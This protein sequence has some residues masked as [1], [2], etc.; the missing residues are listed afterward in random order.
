MREGMIPLAAKLSRSV[1]PLGARLASVFLFILGYTWI[2][3]MFSRLRSARLVL[4]S[5][6][7]HLTRLIA[8]I[9]PRGVSALFARSLWALLS[10]WG[11]VSHVNILIKSRLVPQMHVAESAGSCMSR[12][13]GTSRRPNPAQRSSL[14]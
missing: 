10:A 13:L 1:W 12:N 7:L 6:L 3:V 2:A 11:L 9:R 4:S 14:Q 8:V 5:G